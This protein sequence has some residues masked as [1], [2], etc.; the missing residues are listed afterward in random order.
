MLMYEYVCISHSYM[1]FVIQEEIQNI[2]P[3]ADI[4]E[5]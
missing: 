2:G 1:T 5:E 3:G 4:N